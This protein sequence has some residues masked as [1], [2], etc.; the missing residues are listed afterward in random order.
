MSFKSLLHQKKKKFLL[1]NSQYSILSVS[2]FPLMLKNSVRCDKQ[3]E[4]QCKLNLM[5]HL[6]FP[7]T[8][9]PF[10]LKN[11]CMVCMAAATCMALIL[12][13]MRLK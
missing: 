3:S 6:Y 2:D 12:G 7:E 9:T 1:E 8:V 4:T 10:F 5:L 11:E 13:L